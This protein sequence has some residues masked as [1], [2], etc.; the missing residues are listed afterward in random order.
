VLVLLAVHPHI[1][2][3]A[4]SGADCQA[5]GAPAQD[6]ASDPWKRCADCAQ[7]QDFASD[8]FVSVNAVQDFAS[9]WSSRVVEAVKGEE[10][11]AGRSDKEVRR[12]E[13]PGSGQCLAGA[14]R[15]LGKPQCAGCHLFHIF[16]A[17]C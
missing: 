16:S 14:F 7:L 3:L 8:P 5:I 1:H 6:F 15:P 17:C 9:D 2:T 12:L 13:W 4:F 10:L 11:F